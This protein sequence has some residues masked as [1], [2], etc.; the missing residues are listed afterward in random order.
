L[1]Y[2]KIVKKEGPMARVYREVTNV[3]DADI[4]ERGTTIF[5][6]IVYLIGGF[7]VTVLAI[8]FLFSLLGANRGNGIA[9]FIYDASQPFV[10]PFFGLFNY[11]P[12]FGIARF[13]FETLVAILFYGLITAGLVSLL[14]LGRRY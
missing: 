9:D 11:T 3:P 14:T 7:I 4:P 1:A 8:R 5:A 6:Q 12:Q 10:S 2:P 13:E